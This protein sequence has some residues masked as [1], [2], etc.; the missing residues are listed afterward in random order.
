MQYKNSECA[1]ILNQHEFMVRYLQRFKGTVVRNSSDVSFKRFMSA[2]SLNHIR[3]KM[4]EIY[5]FF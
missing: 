1:Q 3:L 5:L 4:I 2:S